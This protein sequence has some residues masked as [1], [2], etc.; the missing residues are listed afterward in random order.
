MNTVQPIRD[1]EKIHQ[2]HNILSSQ[3]PRNSLLFDL[4]IYSGLR[5]SDILKLQVKDVRNQ[6]SFKL[7]ETKTGKTK[8]MQIHPKLKQILDQYIKGKPD[9]EYL[10]GSR[11]KSD[12][13]TE[14][15][16]VKDPKTNKMKNIKKKVKNTAPNSPISR[17]M[18]WNILNNAA[19]QVGITEI[20]THSLRKTFGYTVYMNDKTKLPLIQKM[21]NHSSQDVTLRYIGIIQEDIDDA[22]CAI[23]YGF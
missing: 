5:I 12:Y 15:T 11:E 9:N 7:K 22:V 20:G 4:G 6:D 23:D 3:S 14:T 21:F 19:Q 16:R 13:I 8:N 10:I 17:V 1:K 2:L 18:A